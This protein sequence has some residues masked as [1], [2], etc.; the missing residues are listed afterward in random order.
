MDDKERQPEGYSDDLSI[1][2]VGMAVI[3]GV[4]MIIGAGSLTWISGC[5][6]VLLV[7]NRQAPDFLPEMFGYTLTLP[8]RITGEYHRIADGARLT[9]HKLLT[10]TRPAVETIDYYED[11]DPRSET[12]LDTWFG[13]NEHVLIIAGTRTG[14]TTLM[15]HTAT[16]WATEGRKVIVLDPDAARGQ[17]PGC[18]VFGLDN[19]M[20]AIKEALRL[21]MKIVYD[22]RQLRSSGR[23][24][25]FA[26]VHIVIDELLA[27]IGDP[28]TREVA[29]LVIFR[30]IGCRGAKLGVHLLMGSQAKNVKA[31]N[32]AGEGELR[33]NLTLLHLQKQR[34]KRIARSETGEEWEI[35]LL[36]DPDSFIKPSSETDNGFL[37]Q[38]LG[39]PGETAGQTA[40]C[41]AVCPSFKG[42]TDINHVICETPGETDET[43]DET[44]DETEELLTPELIR[45]KYREF[46]NNQNAVYRWIKEV[47][48][49]R[50]KKYVLD[51]F[52]K[53]AL[54][55]PTT[56]QRS[57]NPQ[58]SEDCPV[59]FRWLLDEPGDG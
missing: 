10:T 12:E 1:G 55:Q 26:P 59:P 20:Q 18:T 41:Q 19:N 50:N 7:I 25:Q 28:T 8:N 56:N 58:P 43:A 47:Y 17:W 37:E 31:L 38:L 48:G 11:P 51:T 24:R 36:P 54:S 52:V 4:L 44:A 21:I 2:E 29:R 45:R 42:K 13:D 16:R 3:T 57:T 34:G 39:E 40:S 30:E 49:H 22:R 14:K 9:R 32:L 5:I 33:S 23:Q 27:I 35:P 46:G 15:H 53:P 6:T